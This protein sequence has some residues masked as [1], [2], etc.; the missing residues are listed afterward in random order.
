MTT[1][2]LLAQ[3]IALHRMLLF[4][5]VI[6]FMTVEVLH[7]PNHS[8]LLPGH[9]PL[10]GVSFRAPVAKYLK[11]LLIK[12]VF[13]SGHHMLVLTQSFFFEFCL[14]SPI[15]SFERHVALFTLCVLLFGISKRIII[16]I[17]FQSLSVNIALFR[18]R[19]I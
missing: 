2:Y 9:Q 16:F 10:F 3:V 11:I 18:Y 7:Q 19:N 6:F 14:L 8:V 17:Q 5:L 12:T 1:W 4:H 15:S 13:V